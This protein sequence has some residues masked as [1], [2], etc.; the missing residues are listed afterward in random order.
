MINSFQACFYSQLLDEL[1]VLTEMDKHV[2]KQYFPLITRFYCQQLLLQSKPQTYLAR[3]YGIDMNA[4]N[5]YTIGFSNRSLGSELP[6]FRSV[7]GKKLRGSLGRLRIL[8][9][10]GHEAFRGCVVVPVTCDEEIVGFYAHR[11]DRA[12]RGSDQYYWVPLSRPCMFQS[13]EQLV[14]SSVYM[15]CEPLHAIQIGKTTGANAIATDPK[16]TLHN[17][18]L[19]LLVKRKVK[20]VVVFTKTTTS[21]AHIKRLSSRLKKYGLRCQSVPCIAESHYGH[22]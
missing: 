11:I 9:G 21:D 18:D 22:A 2:A 14:S 15:C 3:Q 7:E 16:F 20:D 13:N 19:G 10:T 8:K 4:I 17:A 5:Q 1:P 12:R 6:S